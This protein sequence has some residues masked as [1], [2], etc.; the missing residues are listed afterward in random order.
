M[1][2]QLTIGHIQRQHKRNEDNIYYIN[3]KLVIIIYPVSVLF[4]MAMVETTACFFHTAIGCNRSVGVCVV[5]FEN[6]NFYL[7]RIHDMDKVLDSAYIQSMASLSA[8]NKR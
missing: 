7:E 5:I 1:E 3:V 8:Q 4:S 2:L 6:W